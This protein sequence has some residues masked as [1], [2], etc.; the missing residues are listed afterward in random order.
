MSVSYEHP[1]PA[2]TVDCVVFGLDEADLKVL[3]IR[4]ELDPF[5]GRW[6]LPGGFVRVEE[7]LDDAARRE[8]AEETGLS[9]RVPGAALHLRRPRARPARARGLGGVLRAGE[10][11]GSPGQGRD[12]RARGGVVRGGR[13]PRRSPSITTRSSRS[14][15]S[16]SR[17]RSDTG[18]SGSSSCRRSSRCRSSSGSTRRS[19]SARS[20]SAISGRRRSAPG[21]SWSST[22]SSRTSRT[23]RRGST[24][25][26]AGSTSGSRKTASAS[27]SEAGRRLVRRRR[28]RTPPAARPERRR[29]A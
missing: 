15:W 1:R 3:L 2:L 18:R 21:C 19:S 28:A 11:R 6:A 14:R 16:G 8:L 29:P 13:L 5:R 26:T 25:S 20:T 9:R 23:A 22:R 10:P 24:G 12:R 27:R 17:A 4:R 7:A